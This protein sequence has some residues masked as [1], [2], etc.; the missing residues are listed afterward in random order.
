MRVASKVRTECA[1]CSKDISVY[2]IRKHQRHCFM[3]PDN[4]RLCLVCSKPIRNYRWGNETCGHGCSNIQFRS[5][6]QNGNWKGG[7]AYRKRAKRIHGSTCV[8]CGEDRVVDIH[9]L[10]GNAKNNDIRNL[11]PLCPTHHRYAHSEYLELIEEKILSFVSDSR[12][13]GNPLALGARDR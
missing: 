13:V 8:V 6:E 1:Y 9:H 2:G 10:D 3:N 12:K 11:V 4:L 7:I 5:G